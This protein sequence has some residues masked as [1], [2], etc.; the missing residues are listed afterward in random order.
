MKSAPRKV[1]ARGRP[2]RVGVDPARLLHAPPRSLPCSV[3]HSGQQGRVSMEM[4]SSLC[5]HPA[6]HAVSGTR[7]AQATGTIH[8]SGSGLSPVQGTAV[9][10]W[11]F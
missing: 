7:R 4:S 2:C 8:C 9:S 3:Q 10:S 5:H 11:F 6:A 1:R